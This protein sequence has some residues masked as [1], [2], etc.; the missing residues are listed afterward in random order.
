MT[1]RRTFRAA[2]MDYG[3]EESEKLRE[4]LIVY[5]DQA[6]NEGDMGKAV[7]LSHVIAW[8]AV[9]IPFLFEE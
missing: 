7:V 6:L 1:D 5:R 9:T 4:E 2:E 3:L 8:M